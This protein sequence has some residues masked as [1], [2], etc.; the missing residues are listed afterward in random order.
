M[1]NRRSKN[2]VALNSFDVHTTM[3]TH[4]ANFKKP[5]VGFSARF[6]LEVFAGRK[7]LSA[8]DLQ[9]QKPPKT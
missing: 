4:P 2:S 8:N 9:T 7:I 6:F 3:M 1:A 5:M